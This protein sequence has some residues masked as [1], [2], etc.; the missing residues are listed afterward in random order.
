MDSRM[1]LDLFL[2]KRVQFRLTSRTQEVR[3]KVVE[4]HFLNFLIQMSLL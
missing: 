2:E 1:T 3:C 4:L